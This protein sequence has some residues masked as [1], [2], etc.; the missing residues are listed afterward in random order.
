MNIILYDSN[1]ETFKFHYFIVE[2]TLKNITQITLN[3]IMNSTF[4]VERSR[5]NKII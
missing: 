3:N 1:N 4:I 5:L 2:T